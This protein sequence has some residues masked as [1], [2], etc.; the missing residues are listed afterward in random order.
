MIGSYHQCYRLDGRLIAMGVLDLL[1]HCVSSVYL[2]YDIDVSKGFCTISDEARYHEDFHEWD[3]GKL[4]A[5]R[6]MALAIEENYQL[7]YMGSQ[8]PARYS[9]S[10]LTAD[11][12]RFLHPLVYQD[13]V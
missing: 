8:I 2:M 13:A 7:Y 1:P 12:L 5:M 6:E 3:F 11:S 4:S 10:L 9:E